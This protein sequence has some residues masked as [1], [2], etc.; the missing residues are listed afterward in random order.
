MRQCVELFDQYASYRLVGVITVGISRLPIIG[1]GFPDDLDL[2]ESPHSRIADVLKT[3]HTGSLQI[4]PIR[5]DL[6]RVSWSILSSRND[7][8]VKADFTVHLELPVP[9]RSPLHGSALFIETARADLGFAV[10][11]TVNEL[12]HLVFYD[13]LAGGCVRP[14]DGSTQITGRL[15]KYVSGPAVPILRAVESLYRAEEPDRDIEIRDEDLGIIY[16]S[17]AGLS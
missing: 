5:E 2:G 1:F 7:T 10:A 6:D 16:Q 3:A 17:F 14:E 12:S 11:L 8:P 9:V 15:S 13:V 4:T